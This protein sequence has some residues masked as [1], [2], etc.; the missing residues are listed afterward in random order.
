MDQN[1]LIYVVQKTNRLTYVANFLFKELLGVEHGLTDDLEEWKQYT[2]P[3]LIYDHQP[4]D[5]QPFLYACSLLFENDLKTQQVEVFE[6]KGIAVF[7]KAKDTEKPLLPL[8]S[9][10]GYFL[11][12]ESIRRI[13]TWES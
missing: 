4:N 7:F 13:F 5:H 1:L 8:R 6:Y 2:G 9:I 3:K 10:S 11:H 12:V